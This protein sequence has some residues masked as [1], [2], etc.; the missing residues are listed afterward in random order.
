MPTRMPGKSASRLTL[1]TIPGTMNSET[2]RT[3]RF[4]NDP[5]DASQ[6]AAGRPPGGDSEIL[7][8]YSRAVISVVDSVGPATISVGRS[9]DWTLDNE[10]QPRGSGSGVL[11]TPDGH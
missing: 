5:S 7:D 1:C 2:A 6:P 9:E 11:I 4:L 3:L 10:P 8:A